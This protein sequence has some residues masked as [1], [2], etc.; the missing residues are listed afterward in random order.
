MLHSN[1]I[2]K[3]KTQKRFLI[4]VLI[5]L[6][7]FVFDLLFVFQMRM[8]LIPIFGALDKRARARQQ[9]QKL[10]NSRL[11]SLTYTIDISKI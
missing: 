10:T 2:Q 11:L 3:T 9:Y 6:F 4:F 1:T 5:L 8:I 7:V